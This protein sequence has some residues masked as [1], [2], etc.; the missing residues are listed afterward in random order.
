MRKMEK[1]RV[2]RLVG[3]EDDRWGGTVL[4]FYISVRYHDGERE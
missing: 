1:Q 3:R 2:G 4:L